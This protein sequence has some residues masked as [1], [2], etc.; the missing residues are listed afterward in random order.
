M[1]RQPEALRREIRRWWQR[2][3]HRLDVLD[4]HALA[5]QPWL[6]GVPLLTLATEVFRLLGYLIEEG[7]CPRME[8]AGYL[9]DPTARTVADRP[10]EVCYQRWDLGDSW[11]G[12]R[13]VVGRV[14]S[15]PAC[16]SDVGGLDECARC[17]HR[18]RGLS[19]ET[20]LRRST[21]EGA[22]DAAAAE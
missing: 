10:C 7:D 14:E 22:N 5:R 2:E 13:V 3:G 4:V 12:P 19:L 16:G 8:C 11:R 21:A 9:A 18:P 1:N 17:G 15:C 20:A 6:R